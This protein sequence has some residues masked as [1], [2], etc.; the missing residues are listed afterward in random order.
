MKRLLI[1]L[2]IVSAIILPVHADEIEIPEAPSSAQEYMPHSDETFAQGLAYIFLTAISNLLPDVAEG[3][4]GGLLLICAS[5]AT[6]LIS[7]LNS[8]VKRASE[9]VAVLFS[10]TILLNC[11]HS[12]IRLGIETIEQLDEYGKILLPVMTTV[13]ASSGGV[14][15]SAALY[16][17]T[18]IFSTVLTTVIRRV[19]IP[20]LY[21]YLALCVAD[22]ALGANILAS[23]KKFIKWLMTWLLKLILYVFTGY[24]AVTGVVSGSADA[25]SL[26]ATKLTVSG[27]IPVVGGIISDA[28]EAILVGASVMKN[29]AGIY[30]IFAFLA[31]CIGPILRILIQSIILKIAAALCS[32]FGLKGQAD[33]VED[34]SQ[35]MNMVLAAT[36]SICLLLLISTVAFMKGVG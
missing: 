6:A 22:R 32:L 15:S 17:G 33:L 9:L 11:T 10:A 1:L 35:S 13:M 5:L 26:K 25:V 18:T 31:I 3:I 21:I 28:S 24:I 36:G 16:G 27:M 12:L 8:P 2:F 7:S 20:L 23:F 30:G 4:R 29:A 19:F 34:F 14:T